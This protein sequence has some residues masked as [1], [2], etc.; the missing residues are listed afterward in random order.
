V[1][2]RWQFW[3]LRRRYEGRATIVVGPGREHNF[4]F[5]I[6]GCRT[7]PH[8]AREY[9]R[10]LQAATPEARRVAAAKYPKG[11]LPAL[12]TQGGFYPKGAQP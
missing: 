7:W 11:P 10:E 1:R 12:H 6:D 3:G 9:M 4:G 2:T 8:A 5:T